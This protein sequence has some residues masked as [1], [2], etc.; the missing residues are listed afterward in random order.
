MDFIMSGRLMAT[1]I[2]LFM[3]VQDQSR[4]NSHDDNFLW[5]LHKILFQSSK[6]RNAPL[7]DSV[8]VTII[9]IILLNT[10][11]S[12]IINSNARYPCYTPE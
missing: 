4:S 7:L 6:N 12:A 5:M 2:S 9:S 11:L 8:P 1:S 3:G 10:A